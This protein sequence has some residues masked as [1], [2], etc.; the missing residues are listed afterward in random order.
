MQ[1]CSYNEMMTERR[2]NKQSSKAWWI[3]FETHILT[4]FLKERNV[5]RLSNSII[6]V[7]LQTSS[8]RWTLLLISFLNYSAIKLLYSI[9][10]T[11]LNSIIFILFLLLFMFYFTNNLVYSYETMW[12]S[13]KLMLFWT[14]KVVLFHYAIWLHSLIVFYPAVLFY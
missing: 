2:T 8:I 14:I 6:F 9:S 5:N 10:S 1:F 7:S 3:I 4:A 12:K 13:W 11:S